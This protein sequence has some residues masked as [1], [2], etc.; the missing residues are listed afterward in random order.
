M[1]YD[2]AEYM[3]KY[4]QEHKEEFRAYGAKSR[5]KRRAWLNNVKVSLGCRRC[6]IRDV[7]VLD[8][9]HIDPLEKSFGVS[10]SWHPSREALEE[11]IAKCEVLC[12]NCHRIVEA[13]RRGME[14]KDV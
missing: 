6:G 10:A 11:E 9:H 14:R 7:R 5:A 8:F 12:A 13:E 2:Q 4:L 1:P 3:K